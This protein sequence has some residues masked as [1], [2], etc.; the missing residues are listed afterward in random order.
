MIEISILFSQYQQVSFCFRKEKEIK[1]LNFYSPIPC[2]CTEGFFPLVSSHWLQVA[3]ILGLGLTENKSNSFHWR[4][5]LKMPNPWN[6]ASF[7]LSG[8]IKQIDF[9]L[10]THKK[11]VWIFLLWRLLFSLLFI[12]PSIL[13]VL[14]KHYHWTLLQY[15]DFPWNYSQITQMCIL[16]GGLLSQSQCQVAPF[17]H[18]FLCLC[19]CK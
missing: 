8:I 15:S 5:K 6:A 9:F 10:F 4:G 7:C 2:F 17:W 11:C 16:L 1:M 3:S 18:Q 19:C 13:Y 12:K 14:E